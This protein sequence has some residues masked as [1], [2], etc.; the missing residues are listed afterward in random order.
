MN[1]K[2][3]WLNAGQ[4]TQIYSFSILCF[5]SKV[6]LSS[7]YFCEK[8]FAFCRLCLCTH[9]FILLLAAV[10]SAKLWDVTM[11]VWYRAQLQ[12]CIRVT[13]LVKESWIKIL[14]LLYPIF[15]I[16]QWIRVTVSF[17]DCQRQVL[18]NVINTLNH[19]LIISENKFVYQKFREPLY[20]TVSK[21][22][23]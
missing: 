14:V 8:F 17:S 13:P 22:Y 5:K 4:C 3:Y 18:Y 6:V 1:L 9:H 20:Y 2:F 7:N 15:N 12:R 21:H 23:L 19:Y 11:K 10:N 16:S